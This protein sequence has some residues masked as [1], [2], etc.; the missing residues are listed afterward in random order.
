M[1]YM[2]SLGLVYVAIPKTG[3]TSVIGSIYETCS[4]KDDVQLV[5]EFVDPAFRERYRLNEIGDKKPG[6][7][8]HLSAIQLKYVLGEDEF[9]RCVK[10]SIV[11]NPF[12]WMVSRYFFTHADHEPNA[13]E[14][15]RRHT[16]RH[17]HNKD[18]DTWVKKAWKR[19]KT[20]KNSYSQLAKLVDLEGRVL[21]DHV[22]R[23][24]DVQSTLDWVSAKLGVEPLKMP[25]INGTRR[26]HYS[27]FYS[28]QSKAVVSEMC[29]RDLDYFGYRYEDRSQ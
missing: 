13:Q 9:T 15:K 24:E 7:A 10:F 5:R 2:P 6:R 17:F 18:F 12:A 11:R 26:G 3:S 1:P 14:K 4:S 19:H 8:K 28:E 23:L 16:T 27:Q 25:H 29:A 20:G 22:G 21:V